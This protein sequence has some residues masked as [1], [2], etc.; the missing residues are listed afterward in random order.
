LCAGIEEILSGAW[1]AL[2]LLA[3]EAEAQ[4]ARDQKQSNPS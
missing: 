4:A 2:S 1:Q 3:Q